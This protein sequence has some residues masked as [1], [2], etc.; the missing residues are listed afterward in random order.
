MTFVSGVSLSMLGALLPGHYAWLRRNSH[1]PIALNINTGAVGL[2]E[3]N[4]ASAS[5]VETP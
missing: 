3:Q 5:Q 1:L 2:D 4:A